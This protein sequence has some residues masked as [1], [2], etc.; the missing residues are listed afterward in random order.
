MREPDTDPVLTI[1]REAAFGRPPL[2]DGGLDVLPPPPGPT[3]AVLAFTAHHVIAAAI[4]AEVVRSRIDPTDLSEP[5]SAGFLLFLSGWLG[6]KPGALDVLL[7]AVGPADPAI[8]PLTLW[9]RDDLTDHAR[10][11]RAVRYRPSTV[12]Y[13]DAPDGPIRGLVVV[14]Q[15]LAGR[16]EMAYEVE[17]AHRGAGLGRR[18]ASAAR[19]LVP[20]EEPVFAQVSPG[21]VASLRC[22]VAAGFTPIGSEVLFSDHGASA[23]GEGSASDEPHVEPSEPKAS[24]RDPR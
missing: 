16:W 23:R 18:L 24:E 8:A 1:L 13:A 3:Q 5:M 12:V 4:D 9:P 7:A 19:A 2:A 11:R 21:N 15:G 10:V 22:C 20:A 14:G 17:P 6:M